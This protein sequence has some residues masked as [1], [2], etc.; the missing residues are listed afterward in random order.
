[1]LFQKIT[2]IMEYCFW[3]FEKLFALMIMIYIILPILMLFLDE[4]CGIFVCLFF[5]FPLVPKSFRVWLGNS[6]STYYHS[7]HTDMHGAEPS[8]FIYHYKINLMLWYF[9][10]EPNSCKWM[11]HV[12]CRLKHSFSD[13]KVCR[14]VSC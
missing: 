5:L 6:H 4:L 14:D 1:M 7:I 13:T 11:L 2:K 9:N 12:S 10:F 3:L 8:W